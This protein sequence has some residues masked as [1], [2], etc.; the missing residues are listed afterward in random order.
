MQVAEFFAREMSFLAT[1]SENALFF[2]G[3]TD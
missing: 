2:A 1:P 3:V